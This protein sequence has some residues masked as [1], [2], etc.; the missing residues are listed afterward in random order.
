MSV[1]TS[2]RF[3]VSLFTLLLVLLLPILPGFKLDVATAAGFVVVVVSY[4]IGITKDPG[5]GGWAGVLQSRKFWAALVG[6]VFLIL[7]GFGV[8][9]GIAQDQVLAIV[10]TIAGYISVVAFQAPPPEP[11]EDE[12]V[13][14]ELS[15]YRQP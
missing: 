9:P 1:F 11:I 7:T 4:L 5:P 12:P 8:M 6:F 15:N 10:A 14:P 3:W 2:R 13:N